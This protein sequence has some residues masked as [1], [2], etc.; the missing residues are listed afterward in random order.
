M[1]NGQDM[2]SISGGRGD[3]MLKYLKVLVPVVSTSQEHVSKFQNNLN[4]HD[5]YLHIY[6]YVDRSQCGNVKYIVISRKI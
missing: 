1:G 4:N 5:I 3:T 2:E 6:I